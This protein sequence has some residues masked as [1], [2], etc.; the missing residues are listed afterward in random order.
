[1]DRLASVLAGFAHGVDRAA[2]LEVHLRNAYYRTL[3]RLVREAAANFSRHA[4]HHHARTAAIGDPAQWQMPDRDE[5]L[6]EGDARDALVQATQ[7]IRQKIVTHMMGDALLAVS[8]SFTTTNPLA[9]HVLSMLG[10]R[11]TEITELTRREIMRSLQ[12]SHAKG[13]SIPHAARAMSKDV[14]ATNINRSTL[15]A[16]TEFIGAQN[17]ASLGAVRISEAGSSKTWLATND[18]RTRADHAEADG[19]TVPLDGM[20][21]IGGN[22]MMFPG[23]QNAP[24]DE[25]CNCRCTMT[26]A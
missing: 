26:Y 20:F 24:A 4:I 16:R 3:N 15:I 14:R 11:I 6:P 12:D 25:V 2:P 18:N 5:V 7:P 23:D 10:T 21:D 13:L 19:Q 1:M 8:V 9:Q 17:G 22:P